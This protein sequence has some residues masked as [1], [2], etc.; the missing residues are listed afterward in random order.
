M[1]SAHWG[2][3]SRRSA[4]WATR[5]EWKTFARDV[6]ERRMTQAPPFDQQQIWTATERKRPLLDQRKLNAL[7]PA[8]D[9]IHQHTHRITHGVG[10]AA[11]LPNDLTGVLVILVAVVDQRRERYQPFD[12]HVDQLHEQPELGDA[13]DQSREL[14]AHAVCHELHL[15]PFH[16]LAFGVVG[17][18][19]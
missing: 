8:V 16:Q 4:P 2:L 17:A 1:P 9:A 13:D 19:F 10:L 15:L 3:W 11:A 14:F 6:L 18:T 7:L 5:P 12:E